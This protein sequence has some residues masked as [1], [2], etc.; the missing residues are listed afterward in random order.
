MTSIAELPTPSS[1]IACDCVV[2]GGGIA[3]LWA[4]A[5]LA[6]A[7][8]SCVLVSDAPLGAAQTVCSQGILHRG[9]KYALSPAAA[10]VSRALVAAQTVWDDCL[11]GRGTIDLR[12]VHVLTRQMYMWTKPGLLSGLTGVAASLAM[13]SEVTRLA[14]A[15]LPGAFAGASDRVGVWSVKE[16]CVSAE[17]LV[18]AMAAVPA[19][20]VLIAPP[21]GPRPRLRQES[22]GV[23]VMVGDASIRA[24]AALL[25]AGLGNEAL[26]G[27]LNV[28]ASQACQRRPLRMTL[29]KGVP[30]ELFGHCIKELSDKP[31]LTITSSVDQ[32]GQVVWYI[33]GDVAEL[34]VTRRRDE[35]LAA[36]RRELGECLP[37]I[38]FARVRLADFEIVRAEGRADGGKRPDGPVLRSFGRAAAVWPTKL[39]LAPLAADMALEW[40]RGVIEP[41]AGAPAS[42]SAP[43]QIAPAP[44]RWRDLEWN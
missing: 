5:S 24:R 8:Y 14:K 34:G 30:F 9:V 10:E 40:L 1:A 16:P 25:A 3:G 18:A 13:R 39:A 32:D 31:R 36:V 44:W 6:R 28:Q 22:G 27:D 19:G 17:S 23:S 37:W 33:G 4:R 7:G 43:V 41:G 38:D 2:I 11:A 35:H 20:P 29:A 42:I 21:G 15:D 12:S 26:L